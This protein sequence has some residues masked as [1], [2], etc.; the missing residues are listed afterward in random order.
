M[1]KNT[2]VSEA[3]VKELDKGFSVVIFPEGSRSLYRTKNY[4]A[5]HKSVP[6]KIK[7]QR[8]VIAIAL[9]ANRPLVPVVIRYKPLVLGRKQKWYD[10]PRSVCKVELVFQ[11]AF[12]LT[13]LEDS[14]PFNA[15]LERRKIMTHIEEFY[16]KELNSYACGAK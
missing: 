14:Q 10:T 12:S 8:G 16:S 1:S 4:Q 13:S 9:S 11:E 5:D 7:F 2:A 3:A 6:A 15:P